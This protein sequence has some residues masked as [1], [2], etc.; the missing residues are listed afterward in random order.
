VDDLVAARSPAQ[1]S[2]FQRRILD[3]DTK[4]TLHRVETLDSPALRALHD[5]YLL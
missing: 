5:A 1:I 4:V 2:D 3:L